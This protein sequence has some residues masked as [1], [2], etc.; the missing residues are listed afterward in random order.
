MH[1]MKKQVLLIILL[2]LPLWLK[3]ADVSVT[4]LRTEQMVDPMGLDTAAPRMSWRLESSQRNVMQTAYRILVASSPELLAQDKGDLWDSGKVESDA[5]RMDSLSRE[6]FE[7]QSACLLE[8]E[9]LY[10]SR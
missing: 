6:A 9:K 2:A 4:G 5:V 7:K 10:Q 8:S 3:A 1:I